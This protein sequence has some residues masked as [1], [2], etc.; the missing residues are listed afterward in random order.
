MAATR[1]APLPT[2]APV[3]RMTWL[4]APVRPVDERAS[5]RRNPGRPATG[6][7]RWPA[8][9]PTC[10]CRQAHQY[11][12]VDL[13]QIP[14]RPDPPV[15]LVHDEG[16]DQADRRPT[17]NP[18]GKMSNGFG[19]DGL[20]GGRALLMIDPPEG[21][22]SSVVS[23]ATWL[24]NELSWP[25]SEFELL[26]AAA[27]CD[28]LVRQAAN[29]NGQFCRRRFQGADPGLRARSGYWRRRSCSSWYRSGTPARMIG[30]G[31][32]TDADTPGN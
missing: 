29:F 20:D 24:F 17:S 9:P 12:H 27:R 16:E 2:L 6:G 11:R 22:V 18:L 3:T 10:F 14:R 4:P 7:R 23:A 1:L 26:G 8:R 30:T 15:S 28:E 21:L 31:P 32:P 5:S 25:W 13:D 19:L